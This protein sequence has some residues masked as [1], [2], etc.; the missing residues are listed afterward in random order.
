MCVYVC[1]LAVN[2]AGLT[3][4]CKMWTW[5]ADTHS[6]SRPVPSSFSHGI[7]CSGATV[8][9]VH[10]LHTFHTLAWWSGTPPTD[11]PD[12]RTVRNSVCH[13][14]ILLCKTPIKTVFVIASWTQ[15]GPRRDMLIPFV[16]LEQMSLCLAS[17]S[18]PLLL[19]VVIPHFL[20]S[21]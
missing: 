16:Q 2:K 3:E 5:W 19:L 21:F 12:R 10:T 7:M 17:Q 11:L 1:V 8:A 13:T 18:R 6:L 4:V 9:E 20:S 15:A 14:G